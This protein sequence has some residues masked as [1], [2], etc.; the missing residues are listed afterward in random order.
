MAKPKITDHLKRK[1]RI[2]WARFLNSAEGQKGL[3]YL[4]LA[5]PRKSAENDADLIRNSV[6]FEFWQACVEEI[7]EI[8]NIVDAPERADI[9]DPLER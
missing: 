3:L 8:G 2:E 9:D 5:F 1:E 6:G 4:K 7:E